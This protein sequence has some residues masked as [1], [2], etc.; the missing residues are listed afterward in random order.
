VERNGTVI[1]NPQPDF[2]LRK[3]D[4]VHLI[5]SEQEVGTAIALI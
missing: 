5:G 1:T 2:V 4:R 3:G